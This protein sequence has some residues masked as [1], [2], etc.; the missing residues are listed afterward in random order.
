VVGNAYLAR[1]GASS[2]APSPVQVGSLTATPNSVTT[3]S[4]VTLTAGGITTTNTGATITTVAFYTVD[5]AGTEQF[6]GYGTQNPD[7]TWTLTF[8]FTSDPVFS[9]YTLRALAVDST[10]AVSDPF[11][12]NLNVT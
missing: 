10:G 12:A 6:V 1:F 9:P 3:G 7:G 8:T 2:A 11:A 5:N 4:P